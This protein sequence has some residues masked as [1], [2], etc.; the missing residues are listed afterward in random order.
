MGIA[1][2]V[3]GREAPL[4]AAWLG[5][6]WM[7]TPGWAPS[8]SVECCSHVGQAHAMPCLHSVASRTRTGA[9]HATEELTKFGRGLSE[10]S[11]VALNSRLSGTDEKPLKNVTF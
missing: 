3:G 8:C 4:L 1:M 7:R 6:D 10:Q 11:L 5:P 9:P 2:M